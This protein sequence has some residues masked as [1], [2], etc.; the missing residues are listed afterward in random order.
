MSSTGRLYK[1]K[2]FLEAQVVAP[3]DV[4]ASK[5][6]D[7]VAAFREL[8][9]K[10][11]ADADG[12]PNATGVSQA[13]IL[14]AHRAKYRVEGVDYAI[15]DGE[16]ESAFT[17][18]LAAAVKRCLDVEDRSVA[19][20]TCQRLLTLATTLLSQAGLAVVET[21]CGE[22]SQLALSGGV[23]NTVYEV[24]KVAAEVPTWE[25]RA[26][27]E[28]KG[29][30]EF[31]QASGTEDG[32]QP[33]S[34]DSLL[35]RCSVIR[36]AL[37]GLSQGGV[38]INV[39]ELADCVNLVDTAGRPIRGLHFSRTMQGLGRAMVP[40]CPLEPLDDPEPKVPP[41]PPSETVG[42]AGMLVGDLPQLAPPMSPSP[43]LLQPSFTRAALHATDV[44]RQASQ[45]RAVQRM[46][47]EPQL[48]QGATT[49]TTYVVGD[50]V[51]YYGASQGRWIPAKV[52]GMR[53]D[54]TYDLD[55]KMAVRIDRMR[56]LLPAAAQSV[57]KAAGGDGVHRGWH[58]TPGDPVDYFSATAGRWI[59]AVVQT[60][61]ANGT[62]DL[63]CKAEVTSY[64]IRARSAE[65]EAAATTGGSMG[66]SAA[67]GQPV[68]TALE[69]SQFSVNEV[70][71]YYS[72][73][74][75]QWI[76]ALVLAVNA[77]GTYHLDCKPDV[78]P[79]RMRKLLGGRTSSA[80][81]VAAADALSETLPQAVPAMTGKVNALGGMIAMNTGILPGR[82]GPYPMAPQA[83]AGG[84][85]GSAPFLGWTF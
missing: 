70:V 14:D 7:R 47:T 34:A 27:F 55:C 78:R 2:S 59:P 16:A 72:S 42:L 29:F 46:V 22:S 24:Q 38:A 62:Y 26:T 37:D 35:R 49:P 30:R 48:H 64:R 40:G 25:L 73:S 71:E 51:E 13:F 33:C 82:L 77:S 19:P 58:W 43:I 28:A 57:V 68:E 85:V 53:P 9:E 36:L 61:H 84:P 69:F 44:E 17:A 21:A 60:V 83:N 8:L 1:A 45:V 6:R 3:I 12:K 80:R 79:D 66:G 18:R 32:P 39:L 50:V 52:L 67:L 11:V 74:A 10:E 76:R 65:T 56:R 15:E 81:P 5:H 23:R 31:F 41:S 63:N 20:A 54:G 4:E 75:Q